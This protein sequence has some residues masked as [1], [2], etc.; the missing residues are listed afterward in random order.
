V[1]SET[2][3]Y[4]CWRGL[5]YGDKNGRA[6]EGGEEGEFAGG[7]EWGEGGG[8]GWAGQDPRRTEGEECRVC[9][10]VEE[11]DA[12]VAYGNPFFGYIY[13]CGRCILPSL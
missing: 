4:R 2:G 7:A 8:G 10:E 9:G 3:V 1:G 5:L 6:G 12:E 13:R 11:N